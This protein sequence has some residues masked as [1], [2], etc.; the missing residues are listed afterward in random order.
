MR[1]QRLL[2]MLLGVLAG[3]CS[4]STKEQLIRS[5]KAQESPLPL[6]KIEPSI[7]VREVP[8][9]DGVVM[10]DELTLRD[11]HRRWLGDARIT[12]PYNEAELIAFAQSIKA[13][14]ILIYESFYRDLIFPSHGKYPCRVRFMQRDE[15]R[16]LDN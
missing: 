5:F 9:I 3:G 13:Q 16:R 14:E 7:A 15:P 6:E 10:P 2:L 12:H 11:W 1:F 8:N 4:Y